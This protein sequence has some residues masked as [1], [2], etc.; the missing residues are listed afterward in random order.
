MSIITFFAR[1]NF[2]RDF[3]RF[4]PDQNDSMETRLKGV[5]STSKN[6]IDGISERVL[7]SGERSLDTFY[8]RYDIN[9]DGLNERILRVVL[10][11]CDTAIDGDRSGRSVA[12]VLIALGETLNQHDPDKDYLSESILETVLD[13]CDVDT[14]DPEEPIHNPILDRYDLDAEY[15]SERTLEMLRNRY[16]FGRECSEQPVAT[17]LVAL[18]EI[19][20][21]YDSDQPVH[22]KPFR[23]HSS[24]SQRR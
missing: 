7:S 6:A 3:D 16:D 1:K 14:D 20:S 23:W 10:D 22:G 24:L 19:M 2:N 15:L 12:R 9:T 18:M 13:H 11:Q 4:S 5:I 21:Q 8:D 17:A